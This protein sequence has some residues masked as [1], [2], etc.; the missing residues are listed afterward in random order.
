MVEKLRAGPP[1]EPRARV[2]HNRGMGLPQ[3]HENIE[4]NHGF[5][6]ATPSRFGFHMAFIFALFT[7]FCLWNSSSYW[8]GFLLISLLFLLAAVF[9]P[10]VLAPL[11]T[12]WTGL[13]IFGARITNPVLL[14]V[15]YFGFITPI[16]LIFRTLSRESLKKKYSAQSTWEDRSASSDLTRQY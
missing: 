12:L 2:D 3:N 8:S 10:F 16:S 5:K 6:V 11:N 9:M 7:A 1:L 15:I 14:A 13:G 4:R